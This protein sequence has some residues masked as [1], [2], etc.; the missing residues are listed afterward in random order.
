MRLPSNRWLNALKATSQNGQF[1]ESNNPPND[2]FIK[3]IYYQFVKLTV[4]LRGISRVGRMGCHHPSLLPLCLTSLSV[5]FQHPTVSHSDSS[6]TS[7][8]G[9]AV[10]L[11]GRR[12]PLSSLISSKQQGSEANPI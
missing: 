1:S 5:P 10:S 2:Q 7:S 12:C 11:N 3:F 4:M 9:F 8:Q 6:V